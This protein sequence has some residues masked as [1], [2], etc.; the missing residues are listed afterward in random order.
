MTR[1]SGPKPPFFRTR[2]L[3]P[4]R[5]GFLYG[6]G[7]ASFGATLWRP[8]QGW[9]QAPADTDTV[10]IQM[11]L[12]PL[13]DPRIYDWTEMG[14]AT[15]GVL[16]NLLRLHHDGG[17]EEVLLDSWEVNPEATD[18]L[19]RLKPGL[20]WNTGAPVTADHVAA[21]LEGWAD[22]TVP[23][24]S[25]ATR[26]AALVSPATGKLKPETISVQE[27]LTVRIRLDSPDCTLIAS[28]ADYPAAV[29]HPDH[30]GKSVLDH[31]VGTGAFRITDYTEGEKAVL[32]RIE[33]HGDGRAALSRVEFLDLGP[34]PNVWQTAAEDG[35][36]DML[37][38][39]DVSSKAGFTDLGWTLS[40]TR[41]ATTVVIRANQRA[42]IEGRRPYADPRVRRALALAVDNAVCLEL[43]IGGYGTVAENHHVSP[44]QPDYAPLPPI[45][46]DIEAAR[47]LMAEAGMMDFT[48]ELV[49]VDDS[50]RRASADA[51]AAQL[52]DAG[53]K[54]RRRIL[55]GGEYSANWASYP[56]STTNWNHRPLGVQVLDLAYRSTS[57]WNES[58]YENPD[59]DALLDAAKGIADPAER[60]S[61]MAQLQHRMQEDGVVIQPFWQTLFRQTRP[62]LTGAD[63]HPQ[64]EIDIHDLGW[65]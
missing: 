44:I 20:S 54:V 3:A 4:N 35:E 19:L 15:R 58:G 40:E 26:L 29:Q 32:E 48:H 21:N 38:H 57:T 34:D 46:Q 39:G 63:M 11:D 61:V 41:S 23:G 49:S 25:M 59:F 14:N 37:T 33:G 18:F 50:W 9:A 47:A 30:I 52:L 16:Q 7:A 17:F 36:I 55:P 62:G 60:R 12:R 56:L 64:F 65:T 53:F 51:V 42:E 22:S 28:L 45:G 43:G 13:P 6:A 5:R 31:G 10:R 8:E 2:L 27:D 24:N 1:R